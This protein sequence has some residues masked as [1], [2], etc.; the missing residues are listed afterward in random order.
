MPLKCKNDLGKCQGCVTQ[1]LKVWISYNFHATYRLISV[2]FLNVR[3]LETHFNYF[4]YFS[5]SNKKLK[6]VDFQQQSL[7][8]QQTLQQQ[9]Q[10]IL[11]AQL[12]NQ[13]LSYMKPEAV[14][15]ALKNEMKAMTAM[16]AMTAARNDS[17]A[18][19]MGSQLGAL[20]AHHQQMSQAAAAANKVAT[21]MANMNLRSHV[22]GH[23]GGPVGMPQQAS[24]PGPTY[25]PTPIQRPQGKYLTCVVIFVEISS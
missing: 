17:L 12:R 14:A 24:T 20:Q 4:S 16:T 5:G 9:Q 18:A 1:P 7:Q 10:Q 11:T 25:S 15:G 21:S 8:Q 23:G 13:S 2:W 3:F 6:L 22:A 19:V